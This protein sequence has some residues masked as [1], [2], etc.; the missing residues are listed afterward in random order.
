[1]KRITIAVYVCLAGALVPISK[2]QDRSTPDTHYIFKTLVGMLPPN[3]WGSAELC[4]NMIQRT[5]RLPCTATRI[6]RGW[7]RVFPQ[8]PSKATVSRRD[9]ATRVTA[10]T[11]REAGSKARR[12]VPCRSTT[13]PG[14][15]ME[16]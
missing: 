7:P 3:C 13:L 10:R 12:G 14:Q 8:R 11:L 1:M 6:T 15:M 9:K 2:A 5:P 16:G 4:L